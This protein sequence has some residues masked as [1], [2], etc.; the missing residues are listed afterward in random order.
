MEEEKEKQRLVRSN[1][2]QGKRRRTNQNIRGGA[3]AAAKQKTERRRIEPE[4]KKNQIKC[5]HLKIELHEF[6][7]AFILPFPNS[8]GRCCWMC[9]RRKREHRPPSWGGAIRLRETTKKQADTRQ[10]CL[11]EAELTGPHEDGGGDNL[12]LKYRT[13]V[14]KMAQQW[15]LATFRPEKH[16]LVEQDG[17]DPTAHGKADRTGPGSWTWTPRLSLL[18]ACDADEYRLCPRG[19]GSCFLAVGWN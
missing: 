18:P 10:M 11:P 16:S 12:L 6:H 3:S 9:R 17:T 8:R 2:V 14:G 4:V 7:F 19:C 15:C 5:L 1:P 13:T